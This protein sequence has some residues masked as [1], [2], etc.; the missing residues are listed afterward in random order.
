[1]V[2]RDGHQAGL[3]WDQ[4]CTSIRVRDARQRPETHARRPGQQHVTAR[5]L[6][7]PRPETAPDSANTRH[8]LSCK[9]APLSYQPGSAERGKKARACED[10]SESERQ[11]RGPSPTGMESRAGLELSCGRADAG[12]TPTP[13]QAR[14]RADDS[15]SERQLRVPS[16]TGMDTRA[17]PELSCGR[18]DTGAAPTSRQQ[19]QQLTTKGKAQTQ[20][21]APAPA[22][23][24]AQAQAHAQT[25]VPARARAQARTQAQKKGKKRGKQ[26]S[27]AA[28]QYDS[29][30]R[31]DQN[32]NSDSR[33]G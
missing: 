3:S 4:S 16:P 31:Q 26:K 32:T 22:H 15:E 12:V 5:R 24:Q 2:R 19:Q 11:V 7:C 30:K 17:G 21:P 29:K 25:Q 9:P 27:G 10:D 13:T 20:A 28:R 14:A 6:R 33:E 8:T 18:A 23:A 1:M